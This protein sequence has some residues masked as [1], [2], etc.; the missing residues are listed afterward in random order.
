MSST[1]P[2]QSEEPGTALIGA[3]FSP[4]EL[5][6]LLIKHYG[7]HEGVFNLQIEYQVG[8]GAVGPDP[9][10][11]TPGMMFGISKIGLVEAATPT[12]VS[13]NA[14]AVNPAPAA[15]KPAAKKARKAEG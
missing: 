8:T 15:A 13:I 6:V 1:E 9:E 7:L 2:K 11:M 10:N 14:A 12:A 5:G 4:K 3:A